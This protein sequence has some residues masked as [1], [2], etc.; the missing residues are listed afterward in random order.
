MALVAL[1]SRPQLSSCRRSRPALPAPRMLCV[2]SSLINHRK[3]SRIR[4]FRTEPSAFALENLGKW[5]VDPPKA[6]EHAR[7]AP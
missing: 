6:Y 4:Y 3:Q 7:S 5:L 2:P 1:Q